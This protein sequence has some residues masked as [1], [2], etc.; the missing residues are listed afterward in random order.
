MITISANLSLI[1]RGFQ[2]MK[3][4]KLYFLLL[5]IVLIFLALSLIKVNDIKILK[6][7]DKIAFAAQINKKE[8]GLIKENNLIEEKI[9]KGKRIVIDPG[10]GG[11]DVGAIG[12]SGT[13]EK[14]VTLTLATNLQRELENKTGATVILTRDK[15][16]TLSLKDRLELAKS[17]N[18]D[19]FISIHFDAFTSNEVNGITT[20]YNNEADRSLAALIHRHLFKQDCLVLNSWKNEGLNL[21]PISINISADRFISADFVPN[22][23]RILEETKLEG[24]WLEIEITETSILDNQSLVEKTINEL[25]KI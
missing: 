16:V 14:D 7:V 20:Y 10:H 5:L 9:L 15:D 1:E 23:T 25:K 6:T 3:K 8:Q 22:I 21:I 18:A 17:K 11:K 12:Q 4:K 13:L 19:L 24:K 2:Y